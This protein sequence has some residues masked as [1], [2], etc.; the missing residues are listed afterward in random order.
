MQ[1]IY[2]EETL[3]PSNV[4]GVTIAGTDLEQFLPK[5]F[6]LPENSPFLEKSPP[7]TAKTLPKPHHKPSV[8]QAIQKVRISSFMP[9]MGRCNKCYGEIIFCALCSFRHNICESRYTWG[10]A[11]SNPWQIRDLWS[12]PEISAHNAVVNILQKTSH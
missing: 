11:V 2:E 6:G 7:N 8:R 4:Q 5:N 10:M 9:I 1:I 3:Q 12:F